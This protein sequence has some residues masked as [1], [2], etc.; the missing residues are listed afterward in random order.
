MI[1]FVLNVLKIARFATTILVVINAFKDIVI[2]WK[3]L[4]VWKVVLYVPLGITL[5][6]ILSNY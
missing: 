1:K 4:P 5:T 2:S 3:T 6:I